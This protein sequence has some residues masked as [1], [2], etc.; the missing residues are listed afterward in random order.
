MKNS[1]FSKTFLWMAIGLALTFATGFAVSQ[2]PKMLYSIFGGYGYWIFVIVEFLLV[3]F[4]SAKVM[5]LNPT[6]AKIAFLLYSFVS[7]LTFSSIFVVYHLNSIMFV[8]LISAAVFGIMALIGNKTSLDLTKIGTYLFMGLFAAIITALINMFIGSDTITLVVSIVCV[9][10]FIGITA[11]DVQKIKQLSDSGLPEE[12]LA[13]YGALEL[14]LDFINI[15]I[16][17]LSII[18]DKDN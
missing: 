4:L 16:H 8:F 6:T 3:I 9:I 15:F 5:D 11:Y 1:L 18:G 13:I 10:L 17:I 14:Y 7:G 2:F 12:N